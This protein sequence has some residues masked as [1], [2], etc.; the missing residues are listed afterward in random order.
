MPNNDIPYFIITPLDLVI[1]FYTLS[2]PFLISL[3]YF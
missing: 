1:A 2:L 3:S